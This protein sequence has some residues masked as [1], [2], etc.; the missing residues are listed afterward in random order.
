MADCWTR[1]RVWW[2]ILRGIDS[3]RVDTIRGG[4]GIP[5]TPMVAKGPV[6]R[7]ESQRFLWLMWTRA[8]QIVSLLRLRPFDCSSEQG[9][10]QERHRRIALTALSNLGTRTI[11]YLTFFVS[12]PLTVRYLGEERYGLWMTISSV[13]AMLSFADLGLGNGLLNG[14]SE[15]YGKNDREMARRYVSSTMLMLL[16]VAGILALA[17]AVAYPWIPWSRLCNVKSP[18]AVAESGPAVVVFMGCF[19]LGLPLSIVARVQLG[20]QEGFANSLWTA[21]GYLLG[22]AAL[23]LAVRLRAGLPWLVAAMTGAPLLAALTNGLVVFGW[24]YRWLLPTWRSASMAAGVRILRMG[25]LFFALQ[26][27]VALTF[28]S[29]NLIIARILGPEAVTHYS[30][31]V[32]LFAAIGML[33]GM[34][35]M[36]LWPA[37]GESITRGDVAWIRRTLSRS[38]LLSLVLSA[39][40]SAILVMVGRPFIRWWA[41]PQI[42]PSFALLLGLGVWSVLA[43]VGN[44]ASMF[45]NGVNQIGFQV[46]TALVMGVCS[47][48]AKIVLARKAGLS[49]VIWGSIGAFVV[50]SVVPITIWIVRFLRRLGEGAVAPLRPGAGADASASETV[51]L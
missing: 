47:V 36:P 6:E 31:P 45:M 32:R 38:L 26:V 29:D 21:A 41:G 11:S 8:I 17:F 34:V 40:A 30:V 50:C 15:A 28:A 22:L 27:A 24:R 33:L 9:R 14:I 1:V 12:V 16:A 10:S 39:L 2:I 42:H 23:I 48:G 46:A 18:L 19:L 13:V 44:A 20:Y 37:Y 35:L 43:A 5:G 4:F 7:R 25:I 3:A 49:G 51:T